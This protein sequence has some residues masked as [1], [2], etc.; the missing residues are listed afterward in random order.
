M[1]QAYGETLE[2]RLQTA[3]EQINGVHA[4]RVILDK[5][6][7]IAEIH[8]VSASSR[9]PKQIVRDTESLLHAHFGIHVDYRKISLVQLGADEPSALRMRLRFVSA[10]TETQPSPHVR[11]AL[12]TKEAVQGIAWLEA[13]ASESAM[14][15]AAAARAGCA[16]SE[17]SQLPGSHPLP[18]KLSAPG[19]RG[20]GS[21]VR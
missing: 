9:R 14:V 21:Q 7:H 8:L 1:S 15:R 5:Q 11:V 20:E 16:S 12:R 10:E 2:H 6:E 19:A 18:G 3:I 13:G 4:A 17:T